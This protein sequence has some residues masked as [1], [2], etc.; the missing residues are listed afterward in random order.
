MFRHLVTNEHLQQE[1]PV[2]CNVQQMPLG[3]LNHPRCIWQ[4]MESLF[5]LVLLVLQLL[6]LLCA[7]ATS[8]TGT[9]DEDGGWMDGWMAMVVVILVVAAVGCCKRMPGLAIISPAPPPLST[10]SGVFVGRFSAAPKIFS[11]IISA[12]IEEGGFVLL[13]LPCGISVVDTMWQRS[14]AVFVRC[15]VQLLPCAKRKTP[16]AL[17]DLVSS[18]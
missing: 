16:P 13:P 9:C 15:F 3:E 5:P 6:G 14:L 17:S 2:S 7:S 12:H 10:P 1:L 8:R 11:S 18:I 4:P